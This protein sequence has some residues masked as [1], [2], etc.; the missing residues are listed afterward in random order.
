MRADWNCS[1][2]HIFREQNCAANALAAKSFE[3]D[4]A[5]QI[6][7]KVPPF[8]VDILA[9]DACGVSRPRFFSA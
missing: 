9:A 2:R 6:F 8:L 7:D 5:L 4:P 1:V 3:F